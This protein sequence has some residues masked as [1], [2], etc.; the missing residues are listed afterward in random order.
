MTIRPKVSFVFFSFSL[1]VL[2]ESEKGVFLFF[3]STH[4]NFY[5]SSCMYGQMSAWCP[6]Y[7]ACLDQWWLW[8]SSYSLCYSLS[9]PINERRVEWP[10]VH[11]LLTTFSTIRYGLRI[12]FTIIYRKKCRASQ[13]LILP[14]FLFP[15]QQIIEGLAMIFFLSWQMPAMLSIVST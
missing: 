9:K 12:V 13:M 15:I 10:F 11:I 4:E 8:W 6:Y 14:F 2:I 1:I 3:L 5:V 7:S